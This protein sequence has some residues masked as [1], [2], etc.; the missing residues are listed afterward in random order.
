[1]GDEDEEEELMGRYWEV[2][3]RGVCVRVV[4]WDAMEE[5]VTILSGDGEGGLGVRESMGGLRDEVGGEVS[6]REI[7]DDSAK[8]KGATQSGIFCM[9]GTFVGRGS[10]KGWTTGGGRL[11]KFLCLDRGEG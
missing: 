1:M 4:V 8:A 11:A 7:E 10:G 9:E 6:G 3:K 2:V 5:E